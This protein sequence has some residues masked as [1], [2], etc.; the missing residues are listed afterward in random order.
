[1]SDAGKAKRKPGRP[2]GIPASPAQKEAGKRNVKKAAAAKKEKALARREAAEKPRWKQLEDGDISVRDLTDEELVRGEVANNDG[3]W[4]GRRRALNPRIIGRMNTEYKRRIR[5]GLEKLGML[6]LETIEDI[7]DDDE[8]R[9]QQLAAAKMVIEYNVGK[10]PDVVHVGAET[11]F[12]RL[13]QTAFVILRGE[14]NV[15]VEDGD[16]D[17]D[18]VDVEWREVEA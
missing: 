17:G 12:D 10:V 1:M 6:A 4:D 8:A 16:D 3:S 18:A 11:E 15:K 14:D 13:S 7:L 9:A 5:H 2:K